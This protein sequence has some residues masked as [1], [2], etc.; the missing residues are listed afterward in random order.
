M[1]RT[2]DHFCVVWISSNNRAKD[3]A[4][5][6]AGRLAQGDGNIHISHDTSHSLMLSFSVAFNYEL[7]F[8]DHSVDLY[9]KKIFSPCLSFSYDGI[10]AYI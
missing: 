3:P 6:A 7:S 5:M 10:V 1:Y 9:V 4:N 8:I 2:V